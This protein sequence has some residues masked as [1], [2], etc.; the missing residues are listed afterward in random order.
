MLYNIFLPIWALESYCA[1]F[2]ANKHKNDTL[3]TCHSISHHDTI[4][5]SG[6]I[7]CRKGAIYIDFQRLL[8]SRS[9][10]PDKMVS[11]FK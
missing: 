6:S 7:R 5:R 2:R 8:F 9:L 11:G 3:C 4:T 10:S 1:F